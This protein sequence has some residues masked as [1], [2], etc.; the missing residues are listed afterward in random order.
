[1][2]TLSLR[3]TQQVSASNADPAE[4][5][6]MG[7]KNSSG[8]ATG[9][10]GGRSSQSSGAGW[11]ERGRGIE[12]RGAR[13]GSRRADHMSMEV[14]KPV[15][16]KNGYDIRKFDVFAEYEDV[17]H[18]LG[19][20]KTEP[21]NIKLKEDAIPSVVPCRKIPFKL[22]KKFKGELDRMSKNNIIKK[23]DEPTAWANPIVIVKKP[24]K[25]I[26][27]CLDPL[28]LNQSLMRQNFKF[29]TFEEL[30]T[31]IEGAQVFSTLDANKGF[32]Q[33]MLTMK[34]A[35]N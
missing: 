3:T 32:Y 6:A 16:S 25:D 21:Y 31:D 17:F 4:I 22:H 8:T 15:N 12:R 11:N 19:A 1:M 2:L 5:D 34:K 33:I 26:R 23:E 20:I 9:R 13:R 27:I 14:R 28:Y 18:G 35:R 29:P 30:S 7:F 24:N 10:G